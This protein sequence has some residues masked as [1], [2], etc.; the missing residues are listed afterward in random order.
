MTMN[1]SFIDSNIVLYL[2]DEDDR[3]RTIASEILLTQPC[4]SA[5]VLTETANVCKRQFKFT[6]EQVLKLWLDLITDCQLVST[7]DNTFIKGVNL[8]KQY[9]FQVFDALIVASALQA[10]CT[11]LYSEDMQHKMIIEKSLTII[12]PFI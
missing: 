2:F 9:D 7:D 10:K 4:I 8:T 3:K 5:Q 1:R 12:N 11:I 6:K